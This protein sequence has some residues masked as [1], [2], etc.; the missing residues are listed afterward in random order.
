MLIFLSLLLVSLLFEG[1]FFP[2]PHFLQNVNQALLVTV[3]FQFCIYLFDLY[4]LSDDLSLVE[5]ANKITQAFGVG[6]IILGVIYYT[7]PQVIILTK[8]FWSGYLVIFITVLIWRGAYYLVLRKKLFAQDII[9]VGTG[10]L[11]SDVAKIVEGTHDSCYNIIAFVGKG[12]PEYNPNAIKVYENLEDVV[13]PGEAKRVDKIVVALDDRRGT[14]PTEVL[15]KYRLLGVTIE[16]GVGF[17][18]RVAGRILVQWLDPSGIIF[19]EGFELSRTQYVFKRLVDILAAFC[20]LVVSS[21]IFLLSAILIKLDSS[22]PIFYI[23]E[24]VGQANVPFRLIKFRSM[25]ENAEENGAVWAGENDSRVTRLGGFLRKTRIDELPQMWNV[26]KGEMSLV[27]PRPERPVFVSHL[28]RNIQYYSIR[29][30]V[31]PGVSGWAQ[32]CYP[33]GASEEDALRKL[34]YDLYYMK[35]FSISMDMLILFKT[36]KTVL[37]Q[38]GAR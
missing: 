31:K 6:C 7:L 21:P 3:V 20:T 28:V 32:V 26:F 4:D 14:M 34:E 12:E 13:A 25:K 15:L 17:Y 24:R 18:E 37:F 30:S 2:F 36:I 8:V 16:H 27:G 1:S 33:Y 10:Q 29:H 22:G 11:A 19:S 9:I 23:Q 5:T 38:Q 35:N